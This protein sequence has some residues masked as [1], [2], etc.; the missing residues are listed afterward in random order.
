MHYYITQSSTHPTHTTVTQIAC[1]DYRFVILFYLKINFSIIFSGRSTQWYE[2]VYGS[3]LAHNLI[4]LRD[5]F[6]NAKIIRV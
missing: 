3:L 2:N 5:T 1:V 6:T 4:S